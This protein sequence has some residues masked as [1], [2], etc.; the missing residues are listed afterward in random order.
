M[1]TTVD[2]PRIQNSAP[3]TSTP[4]DKTLLSSTA[5]RVAFWALGI[6]FACAQSWIL[7]YEI[8][9]DSISY[10]DMSDA[11]MP[12][13]DWHRLINGVWSPLYPFLLGL[14]R[15]VFHISPV[16]EIADCHLL[17]VLIFVFAFA[18]FEYLLVG[19]KRSAYRSQ[20]ANNKLAALSEWMYLPVAYSL[21]L[22]SAIAQISGEF[23]RAD[24]LMSGFLYFA[25]G[26]LC[27]MRKARATWGQFLLL[28]ATLGMGFL[29]KAPMLPIGTLIL[30]AALLTVA[31]WRPAMKM[32]I[33]G[34]GL[35]LLIGSLYF[36][37]LSR[38]VG[39][40]SLGESSSFNYIVHVDGA[41]PHWYLQ[42]SGLAT[43]AFSR[44]PEKFFS[45]PDAYAFPFSV[46]VTHPLRF[47][48]SYWTAG[49]RP[50]FV[51]NLQIAA[52]HRAITAFT[53]FSQD[54]I[55]IL[56]AALILA[57]L[58]RGTT[59]LYE[60][61]L[62][63]W[64]VWLVGLAGCAMY[65]AIYV[66]ARYVGAFLALFWL[67]VV[68]GLPIPRNLNRQVVGVWVLL[69]V[70]LLLLPTFLATHIYHHELAE[71]NIDAEGA[72]ALS[73]FGIQPGDDV[74]RISPMV[75]DYGPERI[76][77]VEIVAEVDLGQAEE[78]W[79]SSYATQQQLLQAMELRGVKA[80]IATSP[81]LTD[82]NRSQWT[83]LGK[84]RYWVWEPAGRVQKTSK[85]SA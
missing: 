28:G 71:T 62:R 7:R 18:G 66:E 65:L 59:S 13:G 60:A 52:M 46:P 81:R 37:P 58:C 57:L 75:N 49:A 16:N 83:R 39:H 5:L 1:T 73:R 61:A 76:L 8:S 35:M 3:S 23:L 36:V 64:P 42:D 74:A 34:G 30:A 72:L 77:R 24:M 45:Q 32:T 48:P 67:G 79:A 85:T 19:L 43:G 38:Q 78:F 70:G 4:G 14:F 12:G 68:F 11:V 44:K 6:A 15:R 50:H 31:D 21:F 29:A 51:W 55:G 27:R 63:I 20:P 47:D 26:I 82:E 84:T 2:S 22:W 41:K 54:L 17:N 10:L 53:K 40:F 69:V 25:C 33:G 80:V 9:S 56:A